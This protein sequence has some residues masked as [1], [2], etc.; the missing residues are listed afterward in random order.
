MSGVLEQQ[1][2][3]KAAS[4]KR[5]RLHPQI[6][7]VVAVVALVVAG[8]GAW[9]WN[10]S[11]VATAPTSAPPVHVP[12][13][14]RLSWPP[15]ALVAPI[16]L[17]VSES[18]RDLQLDPNRDYRIVLPNRPVILL[19]GLV[20][21]GG[22]NVVLIG[23]DIE[24]P[25]VATAPAPEQ[26]RGLYLHN[27]TGTI[28]I[29]GLHIGG[30]DLSEGI[31]LDQRLGAVVQLENISVD[32]VEG[33]RESNHADLIQTW[34]GPRVLQVD[35]FSGT[36]SYQGFFLLPQQHCPECLPDSFDLRRVVIRGDENS[37]YLLWTSDSAPWMSTTDVVLVDVPGRNRDISRA[38]MPLN[39]WDGVRLQTN[40]N[41]IRL[42]AGSPG[43]GY[44]SPGYAPLDG[45]GP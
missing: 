44:Q 35:G 41:D 1:A 14:D 26:R 7:A 9:R 29:E 11:Q 22:H 17:D 40:D 24:V 45:Q 19:G 39:P 25:D 38:V 43:V 31:D 37:G 28:H 15:P 42:P 23:G 5:R 34:G 6:V 18:N 21:T 8:F 3:E 36:T 32:K 12:V 4:P 16:T 2:A 27:Q 13:N 10:Q 20:I 30:A 33:T